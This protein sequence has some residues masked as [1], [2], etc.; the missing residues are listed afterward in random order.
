MFEET[1][2]QAGKPFQV[3]T[4]E[5]TVRSLHGVAYTRLWNA[6]LITTLREFSASL[7]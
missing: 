2:P 4:T 6:D 5:D 3:L 1:L 7:A